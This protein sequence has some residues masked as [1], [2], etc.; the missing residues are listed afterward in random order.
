[1]KYFSLMFFLFS[2]NLFAVENIEEINPFW[3]Q[4]KCFKC[5]GVIGETK[6]GRYTPLSNKNTIYIRNKLS[7]MK[8]KHKFHY[9]EDTISEHSPIYD[10][11]RETLK[12]L[13]Y[14]LGRG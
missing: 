2:F 10:L 14:Y 11:D 12:I 7:T 5:H 1:M 9:S 8:F 13:S 3:Q 6:L 4:N